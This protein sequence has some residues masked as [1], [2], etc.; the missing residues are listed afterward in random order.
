MKLRKEITELINAGIITPETAQRINEYYDAKSGPPQNKLVIVFGIFGA[1]LISLGI[2]LILA[3]NWDELNRT[4]KTVISFLPLLAGQALCAYTLIKRNNS[5]AWRE[6]SSAFLMIAVGTCLSLISQIYNISGTISSFMLTWM[7]LTL[8]IVYIMRSS[9]ASLMYI[10]GITY[11]ASDV[12][13]WNRTPAEV[14]NYWALLLLILPHFY[15]L[16]RHKRESNFFV[17][18]NWFIPLSVIIALGTIA[19]DAPELMVIAYMSLFGLLYLIGNIPQMREQKVRNNGYLV[20]GSLGTVILLLIL[21]FDFFWQELRQEAYWSNEL[22]YSP[23]FITSSILTVLGLGIFIYQKVKQKPIEIKPV[24]LV[25]LLFIFI[26]IIGL[27]SPMAAVLINLVAL[28]V[29]LMT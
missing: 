12:G 22:I 15:F 8:P 26:F 13:Y 9:M 23:E 28:G 11:Y 21:S 20:L 24:E 2:I 10:A 4:A 29:G 19:N 18:H 14:Y 17:F 5:T 7:L 16:Y 3:H 1:L 25:F 27:E 6:A